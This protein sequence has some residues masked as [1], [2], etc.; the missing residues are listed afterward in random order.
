MRYR[1]MQEGELCAR[2][3]SLFLGYADPAHSAEAFDAEGYFKTGDIGYLTPE[4]AV[5]FTGRIKDL[6]NRGGEKISAKEVEDLLHQHPGR[7]G[8]G[9]GGDA[10]RPPGRDGLRLPDRQAR[11]GSD[12]SMQWPARCRLPASPGRS[13]RR[14]SSWSM[15]SR[16]PLPG[17]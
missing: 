15:N 5:V 17:R 1:R 4:R 2:G 12:S 6:I 11:H 8:R 7:A 16:R 10:A 9:G 14:S 13:T 3:P